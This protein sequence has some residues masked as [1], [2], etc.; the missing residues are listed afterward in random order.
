TRLSGHRGRAPAW[1]GQGPPPDRALGVAAVALASRGRPC[2]RLFGGDGSADVAVV[3]VR[4]PRSLALGQRRT[5]TA[6]A[7][8]VR[9]LARRC[10]SGGG[11]GRRTVGASDATRLAGF[12]KALGG[13]GDDSTR[14]AGITA[15]D[16][17]KAATYPRLR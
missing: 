14:S 1:R 8:V 7:A 15:I 4:A 2:H 10:R 3:G 5:A 16:R 11:A 9:R 17:R 12:G 13:S 6:A